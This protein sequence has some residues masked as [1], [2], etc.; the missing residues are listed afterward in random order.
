MFIESIYIKNFGGT[1]ERTVD[2]KN[3]VN[4]IE[5]ENESGKS[6]VAAFISFMFYGFCDKAQRH[7]YYS[8]GSV[9]ASG[10][11]TLSAKGKRYRI[12]REHIENTGDKVSIIDLESGASVFEGE[13]PCD[14][15]LGVSA[16]VF[17]HTAYIGQATGGFING[18]KVSSSIEN[19]LFS[20]DENI[21]TDKALKK[22]DDARVVLMHKKGKGGRIN[23]LTEQRDELIRRLEKAKQENAAIID[24]EGTL[25]ETEALIEQNEEKLAAC[26]ALLEHYETAKQYR[27]YRKYRGLKKK[28]AELEAV[29]EAVKESYAYNGFLP[30]HDYIAQLESARQ[31]LDRAQEAASELKSETDAQRRKSNQLFEMSMFI[32]KVN[33]HGGIEKVVSRFKSIKTKRIA[34]IIFSVLFFALGMGAGAAGYI[35]R[36]SIANILWIGLGAALTCVIIGIIFALAA[37]RQRINEQEF[38]AEM[39]VDDRAAFNTAISRFVS[40]EN[41]ISL[42]NSRIDDL[43][44]KYTRL[45]AACKEKEDKCLELAAIW[46]K[47]DADS[48]KHK[49]LEVVQLI[50]ENSKELEKYTLARDTIKDQIKG[51]DPAELKARMGERP[52]EE[53]Y[54]NE[55]EIKAAIREDQFYTSST[56]ML[57]QKAATLKNELSV[58]YATVEN[59]TLTGDKVS[60]LTKEIERLTKIHSA[61]L[62]AYEKLSEASKNLRESVAPNLANS[63]AALL[64]AATDGRYTTLGVGKDL[65]MRYEANGA[66][67]KIEYMSEGTKDLAYYSL[68]IALIRLLFKKELPPVIFDE[69]FSALDNQRLG[70][71]LSILSELSKEEIQTLVFTSCQRE[72]LCCKARNIPCNEISL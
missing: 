60:E 61:Y 48:A 26:R 65:E 27:T 21:D 67:H 50:E 39:D 36:N 42:Y 4:I 47:N 1:L 52:Y 13:K 40:D 10:T 54:F 5:G 45:M 15:F 68:R 12:E 8:W 38:L 63:A 11:L 44:E 37:S 56:E 20:A 53:S 30:D 64:S 69:S 31:E 57:K 35:L 51:I 9:C 62:L 18:A 32:E 2:F 58:L 22:L 25:K 19:I 46:G 43:E 55:E 14:I 23:E 33:E 3:G 72:A 6:T 71:M 49:A 29:L 17:T 70:N 24:K 66:S 7:R 16:D 59:P 41:T 28:A 34:M